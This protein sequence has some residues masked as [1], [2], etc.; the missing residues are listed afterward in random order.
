MDLEAMARI[1][2]SLGQLKKLDPLSAPPDTVEIGIQHLSDEYLEAGQP[3][4]NNQELQD[5]K[6]VMERL[7]SQLQATSEGNHRRIQDLEAD[8]EHGRRLNEELRIAADEERRLAQDSKTSLVQAQSRVASLEGVAREDRQTIKALEATVNRHRSEVDNLEGQVVLLRSLLEESRTFSNDLE[9]SHNAI[10]HCKDAFI[11]DLKERIEDFAA[12]QAW[13]QQREAVLDDARERLA[14][15][16]I[17]I[18]ELRLELEGAQQ[19]AVASTNRIIQLEADASAARHRLRTADAENGDLRDE[20]GITAERMYA[21]EDELLAAHEQLDNAENTT[22]QLRQKLEQYVRTLSSLPNTPRIRN[23]IHDV[24]DTDS[25]SD[26]GSIDTLVMDFDEHLQLRLPSD[27]DSPTDTDQDKTLVD[28]FVPVSVH[29]LALD[30][31]AMTLKYKPAEAARIREDDLEEILRAKLQ[32]LS[33]DNRNL[34]S[35][36]S[37]VPVPFDF[38]ANNP[39]EKRHSLHIIPEEE[40]LATSSTLQRVAPPR[41]QTCSSVVTPVDT[42]DGSAFESAALSAE[43]PSLSSPTLSDIW[44]SEARISLALAEEMGGS[45]LDW[46]LP[47]PG[48]GSDSS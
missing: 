3:Q 5:A 48:G 1:S 42:R 20:L 21:L 40:E 47:S 17:E 12:S 37:T 25:V 39:P 11:Q 30:L 9:E 19:N 45:V 32:A 24:N 44:F 13:N 7:V 43:S 22:R 14:A 35:Q 2:E 29:G 27:D 23:D 46:D 38:G 31:E 26:E 4:N 36:L 18:L 28:E 8:I 15:A 34:R 16:D 33:E 6:E 10:M 41:I